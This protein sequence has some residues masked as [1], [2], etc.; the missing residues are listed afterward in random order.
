[1]Y[2]EKSFQDHLFNYLYF[3]SSVH[4]WMV[5]SGEKMARHSSAFLRCSINMT[6]LLQSLYG[7]QWFQYIV[8]YQISYLSFPFISV[9]MSF[10]C[11]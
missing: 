2:F 9:V 1:M 8:S 3:I 7:D 11:Q 10:L 4:F 5:F 6:Y